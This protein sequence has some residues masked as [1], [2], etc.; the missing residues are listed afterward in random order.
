LLVLDEPTF[1]QDASTWD[2]L[3]ALL[4]EQRDAGRAVICVT[5]DE[6]LVGALADR[7]ARMRAGRLTEREGTRASRSAAAPLRRSAALR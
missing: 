4:A 2:E 1:G 6:R 5:H 3:V 7:E